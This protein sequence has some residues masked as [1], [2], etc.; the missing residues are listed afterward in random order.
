[1]EEELNS[2]PKKENTL[3][4]LLTDPI[5]KELDNYVVNQANI[6]VDVAPTME[7]LKKVDDINVERKSNTLFFILLGVIIVLG[8]IGVIILL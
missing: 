1:M 5:E 6:N 7:P 4:D 2:I 8:I 3:D